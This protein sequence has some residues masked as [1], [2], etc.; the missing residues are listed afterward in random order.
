MKILLSYQ[1]VY[2]KKRFYPICNLG[3]GICELMNRKTFN[4]DDV[5]KLKDIGFAISIEEAILGIFD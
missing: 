5:K 1:I 2:G 3:K 4:I